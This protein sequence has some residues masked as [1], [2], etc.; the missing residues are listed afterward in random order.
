MIARTD[1]RG[2][3]T[4]NFDR[5]LETTITIERGW[6]PTTFT[7]EQISAMASALYNPDLF[8]YKLHGDIASPESIILTSQD[9]DRVILSS[10]HVR[11]FLQAIFLNFTILF[12][13]YSLRDPDFNLMLRE[14]NLIFHGYTPQHYALMANP[15]GYMVDHLKS[16]I[17]IQIIPYTMDNGHDIVTAYLQLLQQAAPYPAQRDADG[18]PVTTPEPR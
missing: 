17:N 2:I 13:G 16:S 1:Y 4:T 6:T 14:L 5:I 15:P 9:Y 10:P 7:S 18:E 12:I 11:T 3:V 8:I